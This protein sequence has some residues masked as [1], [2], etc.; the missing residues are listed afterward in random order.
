MTARRVQEEGASDVGQCVS[1]GRCV[2][3]LLGR[4][5]LLVFFGQLDLVQHAIIKGLICLL[6]GKAEP[7]TIELTVLANHSSVLGHELPYRKQDHRSLVFDLVER[8]LNFPVIVDLQDIVPHVVQVSH[9][10]SRTAPIVRV[11]SGQ[12]LA[13][14]VEDDSLRIVLALRG[15]VEGV[16]RSRE[17]KAAQAASQIA[18]EERHVSVH[19]WVGLAFLELLASESLG[20]RSELLLLGCL[21]L[22]QSAIQESGVFAREGADLGRQARAEEEVHRPLVFGLNRPRILSH[23]QT[24]AYLRLY[25]VLLSANA[26]ELIGANAILEDLRL[27]L[28]GEVLRNLIIHPVLEIYVELVLERVPPVVLIR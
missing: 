2:L 28:V 4:Y 22:S 7:G 25:W 21:E 12:D 18:M 20:V 23:L 27:L 13:L 8:Y 15:L 11:H 26:R 1:E 3:F 6:V 17:R 5:D 19:N 16:V 9:V 14:R 10:V 24:I